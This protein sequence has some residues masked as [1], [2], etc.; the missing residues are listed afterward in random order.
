MIYEVW[1]KNK[2]V[3]KVWVKIVFLSI[4]YILLEKKVED[5]GEF[6]YERMSFKGYGR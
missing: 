2:R 3:V 1:G 5:K 6:F 4:S